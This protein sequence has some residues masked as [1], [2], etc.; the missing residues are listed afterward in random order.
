MGAVRIVYLVGFM[1]SGKS[2]VGRLVARRLGWEF[3]DMDGLIEER[4]GRTVGEIFAAEGEKGFRR[5]EKALLGEIAAGE[6]L[7][8]ATGGGVVLDEDNRLTMR[9]SGVSVYLRT[10]S[11]VVWSRIRDEGG[12]PLLE[13]E[14]P[15]ERVCELMRERQHLYELSDYVVDTEGLPPDEVADRV[16]YKLGLGA[17]E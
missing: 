4:E 11:T 15:Y 10:P 17:V 2:T 16:L 9:R 3:V 13:V 6:R 5:K 12:R 7:V 14:N 1:G 8:V